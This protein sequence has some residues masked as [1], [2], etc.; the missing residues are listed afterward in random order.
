MNRRV[1][2]MIDPEEEHLPVQIV[3]A[4]SRAFGNLGWQRK[5]IGGDPGRFRPGR[6]EG[7]D[8]IA[9]QDTRQSPEHIG[10]SPQIRRRRRGA[11]IEGG[12]VIP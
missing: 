9:S 11:W 1:G 3:H 2:I 6:R 12:V 4:T 5:R 7:V 8:V 10:N